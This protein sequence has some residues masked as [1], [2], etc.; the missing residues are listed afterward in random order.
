MCVAMVRSVL[1]VQERAPERLVGQ[2][3][4]ERCSREHDGS[5]RFAP[6]RWSLLT[7]KLTSSIAALRCLM[8]GHDPLTICHPFFSP[9]AWPHPIPKPVPRSKQF[10]GFPPTLVVA[11]EAECLRDEIR[12]L[13]LRMKQGGVRVQHVEEQD[14]LHDHLTFTFMEPERTQ[15]MARISKWIS[16]TV[17]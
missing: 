16:E 1:H 15:T 2:E 14:V 10:V 3:Q 4:A 6:V 9:S 7:G 5:L 12:E 17:R 8:R 11:G 13:V